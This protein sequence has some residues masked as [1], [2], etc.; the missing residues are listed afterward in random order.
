MNCMSM[1]ELNSV[2]WKNKIHAKTDKNVLVIKM[3]LVPVNA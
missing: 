1:T 3:A 2:T